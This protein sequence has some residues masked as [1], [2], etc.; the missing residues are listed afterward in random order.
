PL[1]HLPVAG[2]EHQVSTACV[3]ITTATGL[4][5]ASARSVWTTIDVRPTCSGL[6]TAS[7]CPP[8]TARKKFVFDSIVAV[9]APSGRL[10]NAQIA[11][12]LSASP[13]RAP[14]CRTPPAVHRS[15]AQSRRPRTSSFPAAE[16]STPSPAAKGIAATSSLIG[17]CRHARQLF[18]LE[19]LE[20]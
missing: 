12:R 18:A 10:R 9:L 3:C 4:A 16:T 2:D 13:M 7:T 6:D 17:D 19:Q 11:P 20:R 15:G 14:P 1:V 5:S 8:R